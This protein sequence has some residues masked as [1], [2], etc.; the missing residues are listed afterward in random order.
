MAV[1]TPKVL[2]KKAYKSLTDKEARKA[3]K[4]QY[5]EDKN[6]NNEIEIAKFVCDELDKFSRPEF[7]SQVALSERVYRSGLAG[8]HSLQL[9][10]INKELGDA[11]CMPKST[12]A[13]KEARK[14]AIEI[15]KNKKLAYKTI[16]KNYA[17]IEDF[18]Q[19]D[20]AVLQHYFDMEDECDV[21][22]KAL[23]NEQYLAKKAK[24]YARAGE[25]KDEIANVEAQRKEARKMSKL[26]TDSQANFNRAA[27][28]YLDAEKLLK[29][30]ENYT[31]FEEIAA[32]YDEAKARIED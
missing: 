31:H 26:E 19:P 21:K 4:K 8:I 29:Q 11:R 6:F 30:K 22:L 18:V 7:V 13:E 20:F 23:Y 5:N 9:S 28:P 24:D 16:Q 3:A 2:D 15:A 14:T 10:D 1:A 32:M 17:K 27:K 12:E 25:L